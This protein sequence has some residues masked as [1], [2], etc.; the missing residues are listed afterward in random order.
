[1]KLYVKAATGAATAFE[2]LQAEYDENGI[3]V[4]IDPEEGTFYAYAWLETSP[5]EPLEFVDLSFDFAPLD[6]ADFHT[7]LAGKVAR[8]NKRHKA[9]DPALAPVAESF[10]DDLVRGADGNRPV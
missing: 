8:E 7:K 6:Y 10:F 9:L 1:M 4:E 2:E 3:N 5:A